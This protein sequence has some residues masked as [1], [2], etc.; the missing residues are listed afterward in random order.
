[1]PEGTYG[2]EPGGSYDKS[3]ARGFM[4]GQMLTSQDYKPQMKESQ[5]V[6]DAVMAK[7][8][9]YPPMGTSDNKPEDHPLK[10]N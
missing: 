6:E 3:R 7:T 4:R 9:P 2:L 1:M 5:S 10:G 8:H